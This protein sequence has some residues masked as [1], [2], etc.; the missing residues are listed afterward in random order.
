[1]G[2]SGASAKTNNLREFYKEHKTKANSKSAPSALVD[3]LSFLYI[4]FTSHRTLV[5]MEMW[6]YVLGQISFF[7]C[8]F[9]NG[10]L[11][12][13]CFIVFEMA[14]TWEDLVSIS[15]SIFTFAGFVLFCYSQFTS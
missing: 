11:C 5:R 15:C 9:F 2:S 12:P 8:F 10:D 7:L 13:R 6:D 4:L 14:M 3:D 1:M